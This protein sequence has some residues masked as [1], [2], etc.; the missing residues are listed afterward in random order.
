M[1]QSPHCLYVFLRV[2]AV[3]SKCLGETGVGMALQDDL[4]VHYEGKGIP[5][6]AARLYLYGCCTL[7]ATKSLVLSLKLITSKQ[8]SALLVTRNTAAF[9]SRTSL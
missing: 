4:I 6:A 5:I 2:A 3:L 7:V 8:G 9:L 1:N